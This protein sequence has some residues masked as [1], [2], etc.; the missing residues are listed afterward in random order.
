M[1]TSIGWAENR[2]G[3]EAIGW[4]EDRPPLAIR[5]EIGWYETMADPVVGWAEDL[6]TSE[7][8]W[9]ESDV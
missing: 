7:I 8:G 2:A 1:A 4:Y 6:A 3:A 5:H 9:N